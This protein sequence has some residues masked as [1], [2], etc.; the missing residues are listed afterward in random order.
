MKVLKR[1]RSPATSCGKIHGLRPRVE[2]VEPRALRAALSSGMFEPLAVLGLSPGSGPTVVQVNDLP[3]P[4]TPIGASPQRSDNAS[5]SSVLVVDLNGDGTPDLLSVD[6]AG[7]LLYH[8][9]VAGQSGGF[10]PAIAIDLRSPP[11][12]I[13]SGLRSS[14]PQMFSR[15]SRAS[16][17]F[18]ITKATEFQRPRSMPMAHPGP[19]VE[20]LLALGRGEEEAVAVLGD[21]AGVEVFGVGGLSKATD[22][23]RVSR[24][25]SEDSY[26]AVPK[27]EGDNLAGLIV[28]GILGPYETIPDQG[29]QSPPSCVPWQLVVLEEASLPM[30]MTSLPIE[31]SPPGEGEEA[32]QLPINNGSLAAPPSMLNPWERYLMSLDL[33]LEDLDRNV[34]DSDEDSTGRREPSRL[35]SSIEADPGRTHTDREEVDLS[36]LDRQASRFA[37]DSTGPAMTT[38]AVGAW[39]LRT[40]LHQRV[41]TKSPHDR[42][43][44]GLLILR[45]G[46][47]SSTG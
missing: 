15:A 22:S 30:V 23:Y 40:K 31:I 33:A 43:P 10:E 46:T 20:E 6:A 37:R 24:S 27:S 7:N 38:L 2:L 45:R 35:F 41:R 19:D 18:S 28:A 3:A 12:A 36:K 9:G 39:I 34:A 4:E 16:P 26:P 44:I 25:S 42:S 14:L 11:T 47:G 8:Q 5:P 13:L 1:H 21:S 32:A 29:E 17:G